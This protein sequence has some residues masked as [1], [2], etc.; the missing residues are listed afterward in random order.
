MVER[1]FT[2]EEEFPVFSELQI[3]RERGSPTFSYSE[4]AQFPTIDLRWRSHSYEL[5][6]PIFDPRAMSGD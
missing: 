6:D 4:R 1:G 5:T 3:L 2:G